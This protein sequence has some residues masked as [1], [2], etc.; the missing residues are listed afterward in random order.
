M[1][2]SPNFSDF[3]CKAI[4]PMSK[5]SKALFLE[6]MEGNSIAWTDATHWLIAIEGIIPQEKDAFFQWKIVVFPARKDGTYQTFEIPYYESTLFPTIDSALQHTE[7]KERE[8]S[9]I[10]DDDNEKKVL[11]EN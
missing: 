11:K 10:A 8:L 1:G 9:L 5:K 2:Y 7:V 4:I 6:E 3:Y